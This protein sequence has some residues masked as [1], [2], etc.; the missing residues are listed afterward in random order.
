[1]RYNIKLYGILFCMLLLS[2]C[3]RIVD[4]AKDSFYQGDQLRDYSDIPR[5]FMRSIT[6]YDQ[7]ET[8]GIFDVLWL[9]GPVRT[10]YAQLHAC[11]HGKSCEHEK[12]FLRR[13]LEE[14]KHFIDFYVLS[15]YS[16]PLDVEDAF[17]SLFL[18][19]DGCRYAPREIKAIDLT[20]EYK[21]FFGKRFSKFKVSYI[22]R[23]SACDIENM[24]LIDEDTSCISL[25]F[26]SVEKEA[27]LSWDLT[28]LPC[29]TQLVDC[30]CKEL[31]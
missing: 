4:W 16:K 8:L 30:E 29:A 22:V 10:S 2:G 18:E 3:G 21:F 5:Q 24:P 23:F 15:L 13:Q 17:W 7:F 1:M 25:V 28:K 14:N 12:A 20:P 26:R 31:H 19:I 27:V 11:R 6:V 9:A